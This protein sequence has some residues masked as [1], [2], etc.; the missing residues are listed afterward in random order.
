[1]FAA[2][3]S[4]SEMHSRVQQ[5]LKLAGAVASEPSADVDR[6]LSVR[7]GTTVPSWHAWVTLHKVPLTAG[8]GAQ[9][10]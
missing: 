1:M 2:V 4:T 3:Y 9:A 10:G 5:E 8:E 7:R 6:V